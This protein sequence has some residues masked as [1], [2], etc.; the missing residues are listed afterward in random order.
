V[1]TYLLLGRGAL[2]RESE[3]SLVGHLH[4]KKSLNADLRMHMIEPSDWG[5]SA[6]ASLSTHRL[7][8]IFNC[9]PL[10]AGGGRLVGWATVSWLA[11]VA[12][13]QQARAMLVTKHFSVAV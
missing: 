3:S 6:I 12:L 10:A 2:T 9:D 5:F 8:I 1:F 13:N 7:V 11:D 4:A